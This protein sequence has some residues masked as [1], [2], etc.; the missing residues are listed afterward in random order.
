MEE[1][2]LGRGYVQDVFMSCHYHTGGFQA[3]WQQDV[4]WIGTDSLHARPSRTN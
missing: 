1:R 2:I 3:C 4:K